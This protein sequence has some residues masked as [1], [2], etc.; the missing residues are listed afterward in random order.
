MLLK[1]LGNFVYINICINLFKF[2]IIFYY[3]FNQ[4]QKT[5]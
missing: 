4:G 5:I 2:G 3:W 1:K